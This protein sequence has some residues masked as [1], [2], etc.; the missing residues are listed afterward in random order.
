MDCSV[1]AVE[2]P[3]ISVSGYSPRRLQFIGIEVAR[4][5]VASLVRMLRGGGTAARA[6]RFA[7]PLMLADA[8]ESV[9]WV[10]DAYFIGRLGD[11]AL[12]AVGVG[13]YLSWLWFVGASL[14]MTGV[15]VYAS[16]AYGSGDRMLAGRAI[17]EGVVASF[18]LGI[19]AALAAY[20]LAPVMVSAVAG[21]AGPEVRELAV[22]YFRMRSLGWP[23]VYAAMALDAGYRALEKSRPIMAS[24]LAGAVAN[25]VLDPL[26]IF[27]L[28]PFPEMGVSGA[29]AASVAAGM[30]TLSL[31]LAWLPGQ[32]VPVRPSPPGRLSYEMAR[33]LQLYFLDSLRHASSI[34]D[35]PCNSIS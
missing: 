18:L 24:M 4:A 23:L 14:F 17:G 8:A 31:L 1:L 12:A 26:L 33:L 32:P 30:V 25:A 11:V 34:R 5:A 9:L 21:S 22:E 15:L 19:P 20:L 3:Y 10:V 28:G 2:D 7:V 6:L 35:L 27:G 29:A 16:Q 13:G